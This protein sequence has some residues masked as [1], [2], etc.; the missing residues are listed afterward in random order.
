MRCS[1]EAEKVKRLKLVEGLL[2]TGTRND[3]DNI[4][5]DC[6][7]K[8][9]AL[10]CNDHITLVD[11]KARRAM[12]RKSLMTFFISLVFR[13]EVKIVTT[14]DN[15]SVHRGALNNTTK[16]M[17]TNADISSEGALLVNIMSNNGLTRG[18]ESKANG[19]IVANCSV[20]LL[21]DVAK[22]I[23]RNGILFLE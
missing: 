17:T 22:L 9:S 16:N 14:D 10:T 5:L 12:D 21:S 11:F 1:T 13:A 23:Y 8:R 2:G 18:L 15:S 4:E 3:T 7:G 19:A 20:R 6:L